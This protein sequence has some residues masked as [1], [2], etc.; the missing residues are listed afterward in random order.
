MIRFVFALLIALSA[1]VFADK[2][3]QFETGGMV[4]ARAVVFQGRI[5][6]TGGTKLY[7]LNLEGEQHWDYDAGA[8][9]FSGVAISGKTVFMLA[10]NGLHALDL[11]GKLQWRFETQDSAL[12]VEGK[13]MGW[14]EGMFVDPWAFYRSVPVFAGGKILFSNARGTFAL[15]AASGEQLWYTNTGITHTQPAIHGDIV[16]VGSWDNYLYGLN[17]E[18]GSE[19]W[20]VASRLPGGAMAGWLG[21]EGF[22]LDPVIHKGIVYAGNRGTHF[23]AIDA[24]TGIEQWSSKHPSS[25]IGSP[26]IVSDE[27]VYFGLS[28]GY[29]LKG[30]Q[31][32]MGNQVLLF[33]N[34]FYNFAQPQVNGSHVFMASLSGELFAI[35]KATGQ[36]RELFA[37]E[38]SRKNLAELLAPTGGMKPYY[39]ARDGYSHETASRDV[40]RMLTK[41]NSLL[42]LTLADGVLYAGSANGTLYAIPVR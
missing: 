39:T 2:A 8:A 42:S 38:A 27:V 20:K 10:D 9:S 33:R 14:G 21:W 11:D 25:W 1:N 15:N 18:D 37:T 24:K 29:S 41:L 7:A 28:D 19:V 13:T 23:Y 34:N 32:R 5:Y 6:V 30:L 17:L 40:H 35:E 31:T 12:K 3:W 16:V 36:A 22:N 4:T 26:A